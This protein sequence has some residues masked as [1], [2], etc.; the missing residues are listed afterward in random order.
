ML[1][2]I[3]VVRDQVRKRLRGRGRKGVQGWTWWKHFVLRNGEEGR[4]RRMREEVK[5]ARIYCKHFC[6]CHNV[7][8]A[9]Q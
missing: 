6:K 2:C 9:Q 1:T 3:D 8:P 5:S 7:P 4:E